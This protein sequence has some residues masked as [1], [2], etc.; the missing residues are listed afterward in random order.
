MTHTDTSSPAYLHL[1]PSL[2]AVL[3]WFQY[4]AAVLCHQ[5]SFSAAC[6]SAPGTSL[7]F[8]HLHIGL[9]LSW[10]VLGHAFGLDLC[11]LLQLCC[12]LCCFADGQAAISLCPPLY[13]ARIISLVFF[14]LT[15]SCF[16]H[17]SSFS[18]HQAPS[19]VCSESGLAEALLTCAP[20][21]WSLF[22]P[23]LLRVPQG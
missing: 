10:E 22:V 23:P 4:P 16:A 3:W 12:L 5:M 18:L 19:S 9:S 13:L 14:F 2:Q 6:F 20:L 7:K 21:T 1:A 11:F 17:I 15:P 8:L